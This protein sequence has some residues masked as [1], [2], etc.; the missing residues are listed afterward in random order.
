MGS[1]VF[2]REEADLADLIS[3]HFLVRINHLP[4]IFICMQRHLERAQTSQEVGSLAW[5]A[6]RNMVKT[7]D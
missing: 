3:S 6:R 4:G 5:W 2:T 1:I 7:I